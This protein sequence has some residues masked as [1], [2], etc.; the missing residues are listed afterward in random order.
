MLI[1]T[2]RAEN[3]KLL[4]SLSNIN[5]SSQGW[6]LNFVKV[7]QLGNGIGFGSLSGVLARAGLEKVQLGLPHQRC[8][9]FMPSNR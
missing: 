9:N 8:E 2:A 4:R 1:S 5:N 6:Y 7:G 3:V